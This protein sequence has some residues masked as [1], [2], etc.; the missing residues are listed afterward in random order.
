MGS[1]ASGPVVAARRVTSATQYNADR[2][3]HAKRGQRVSVC[4][5]AR[6]EERTVA[7]IVRAIRDSLMSVG[8][9]NEIVVM[10]DRSTDTTARVA[11]RAGARVVSTSDVFRELGPSRGKGDAI[12]RSLAV[13]TGD[14]LVWCDADLEEF[15]PEIITGLLG[16]LIESPEISL[17]KGFFRRAGE[18][19]SL[20]GGR[21]TELTARP[22][23][24]L[25]APHLAHIREPLSGMFA[26]RRAVMERISI[27]PDYGVDFA[28]LADVVALVGRDA[29][30]QVN[31]GQITH[32]HRPLDDLAGT[33]M[34]V[35]RAILR[36]YPSA[37]LHRGAESVPRPPLTPVSSPLRLVR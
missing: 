1:V 8:L 16:P 12:H 18:G 4:I 11:A 20:S 32:R 30:A 7:A 3:A 37:S 17:V 13:A 29:V 36:R 35:A 5:P 9:V 26:A 6:N 27:E 34:Q 21:V 15:R 25:L 2:L 14:L 31:L 22:L 23:L 33:A 19:G 28:I 10:D 24:Q